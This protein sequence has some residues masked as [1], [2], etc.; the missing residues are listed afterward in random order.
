MGRMHQ[1]SLGQFRCTALLDNERTIDVR[2]EFPQVAEAELLLALKATG[3]SGVDVRVGYNC[4]LVHNGTQNIL[5]DAGTGQDQLLHSLQEAG[6]TPDAIDVLIL[7]HSDF[8]HV[9]GLGN[10]PKAEIIMPRIAWELWTTEEGQQRMIEEFVQVFATML[11]AGFLKRAIA[12]R[13]NLGQTV[14]PGLRE[15]IQLVEEG[16]TFLPG[17]QMHHF[18]GHRSDHFVVEIESV[19]KTL[20]HVADSFRHCLQTR[21]MDWNSTY[22]SWPEQWSESLQKLVGW[23]RDKDAL[24]FGSHLTFPGLARWDG[25]SLMPFSLGR[26]GQGYQ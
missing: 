14:F 8:D 16:E 7:T 3:F 11:E 5:I 1:F 4:L 18:P 21:N 23:I 6:L 20:L 24:V 26:A 12:Y 10:F 2:T 22:D 15:R 17:L 25:E 13:E 9:G 19:G